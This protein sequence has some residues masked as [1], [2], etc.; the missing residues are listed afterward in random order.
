MHNMML[1]HVICTL[2]MNNQ[3][4]AANSNSKPATTIFNKYTAIEIFFS[5]HRR[6]LFFLYSA[7]LRL[8]AFG[9]MIVLGE[10]E[11]VGC[12][13]IGSISLGSSVV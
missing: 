2:I 8:R 3:I 11:I 7:K 1:D 13:R 6:P 12:C 9:L 4:G 10:L 5:V